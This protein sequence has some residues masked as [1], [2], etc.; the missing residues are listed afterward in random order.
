MW[1]FQFWLLLR[2]QLDRTAY[3]DLFRQ[4]LENLLSR[5]TDPIQRQ[6]A[7]AMRDFDWVRYVAGSVRRSGIN[8]QEEI[9]EKIHE[10][11]IR[12]LVSPGGL[13]RDYDERRHGPFPLRFKRTLANTLKNLL[14]RERNRRR[15][16]PSVPIRQEFVPGGVTADDLVSRGEP[17]GDPKLLDE[18]RELVRRQ[19]GAIALRVFDA[20]LEGIEMKTLPGVSSCMVKKSV[21]EIKALARKYA[22]AVGD[23]SL[24]RQVERLMAAEEMTL[25]RR[26]AAMQQRVVA[27]G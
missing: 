20:R 23:P 12:M 6:H 5:L 4:E 17:E 2:E 7:E 8:S 24:L 27:R 16:I 26:K 25:Q 9:D 22:L 19:L 21:Q 1:S 11:A 13:F 15:Y 18:F 3:N 14:E 10:I